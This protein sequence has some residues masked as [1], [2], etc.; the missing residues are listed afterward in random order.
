MSAIAV[1]DANFQSEVLESD[2]PVLVDFW[3][4]WCGPCKA[5]SPVVDAI[6][7]EYAGNV[8]VVKVDVD[9]APRAAANYGVVSIPT[10]LVIQAGKVKNQFTGVR[11]KQALVDAIKPY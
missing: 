6:A 11:P 7:Q 4:P 5:M 1:N 3:A 8:K 10:F 2:L 9:E